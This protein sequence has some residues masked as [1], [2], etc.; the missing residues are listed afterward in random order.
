MK[1]K[2]YNRKLQV[3]RGMKLTLDIQHDAQ[4]TDHVLVTFVFLINTILLRC[5]YLMA[6]DKL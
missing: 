2:Y 5:N 1:K 4:D 6:H 3:N